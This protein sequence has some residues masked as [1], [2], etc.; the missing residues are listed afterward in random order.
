MPIPTQA[1]KAEILNEK[2][3]LL[4]LQRNKD[5][6]GDD[7]FDLPGGLVEDGE[8]EMEALKREV[9]EELG[10]QISI[11]DK[12]GTWSFVRTLD[13]QTVSVQNYRA[14]IVSGEIKL[15]HEH[16]ALTWISPSDIT[17]YSLKDTSL[18]ELILKELLN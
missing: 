3:E 8:D 14:K 11:Q 13:N 2:R 6:R 17:K 5:L 10:V 7:N 4:L 9:E 12:L 16:S 18:K 1:V 15:S